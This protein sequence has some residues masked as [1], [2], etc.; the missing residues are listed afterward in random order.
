MRGST[1]WCRSLADPSKSAAHAVFIFN[2]R[3]ERNLDKLD[4]MYGGRFPERTY[5]MP[6]ARSD[7]ADVCRIVE[8]S[9]HFSGHVAQGLSAFVDEAA[10]HYVFISDDLVLNPRLDATNVAREL[11]LDAET[12]YIKSLAPID[13]LRYEWHRSLPATIALRRNGDGFDWRAELPPEAEARA[14]FAAMGLGDRLATPRTFGQ[15]R[16]AVT[17]LLPAAGYLTAPWAVKM[18]RTPTDYPLLMGYADFFVVPAGAIRRFAH[19]CGVF[20]ALDLF[21]EVAIPTAL[22]L[23]CDRVMTELAPGAR[24]DD[25][26]APRLPD[27]PW[28]GVEFWQP[29]ETPA[30][31]SRFGNSR[32]RLTDEFPE[33]HLYV[34]PVKLSQWD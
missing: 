21:A 27:R 14:R 6:F 25:P 31:A 1:I 8:T 16:R 5:L 13:A 20:A 17:E 26:A 34:H 23:A 2:H 22:A 15:M 29:D 28:R 3:F 24:F 33:D 7:R 30:F 11:G 4:E 10:T 18:Y 32:R 12:G 9:W 19:L